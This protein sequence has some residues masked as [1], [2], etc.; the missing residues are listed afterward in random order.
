M[1]KVVTTVKTDFDMTADF[2]QKKAVFS[3]F[4]AVRHQKIIEYTLY[5]AGA[6][7]SLISKNSDNP[8]NNKWQ[9][10]EKLL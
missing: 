3:V 2:I 7:N 1:L 8:G 9:N 5:F 6:I 4:W 10:A